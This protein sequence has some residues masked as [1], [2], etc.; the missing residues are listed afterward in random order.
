M[1]NHKPQRKKNDIAM[2]ID[3]NGTFKFEIQI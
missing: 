3:Y 1:P 2:F